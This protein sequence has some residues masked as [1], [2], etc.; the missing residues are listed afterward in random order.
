MDLGWT[1]VRSQFQTDML[2]SNM[3][4]EQDQFGHWSSQEQGCVTVNMSRHVNQFNWA[5]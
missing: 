4:S 1:P 5:I 3:R 2:Q